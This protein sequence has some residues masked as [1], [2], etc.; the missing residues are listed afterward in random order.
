MSA[1]APKLFIS[2]RREETAGHAGRLYD[3]VAERFGPANVFM[4]VELAPGIDFVEQ[5]TTA[6][7]DCRALLVVIGPHWASVPVPGGGRSRLAEDGDYVRLEVETA[8]RRAD[9]RVIPVLVAGAR[10]PQPEQ[11]PESLRALAR[12]N[13]IELSDGRWRFDVGRLVDALDTTIAPEPQ[14]PEAE[15]AVRSA[16][17][18]VRPPAAAPARRPAAPQ[19]V[20]EGLAIAVVVG[21][22][23]YRA[24]FD[25]DSSHD[26]AG[27]KLPLFDHTTAAGIVRAWMTW[28]P[29]ALALAA[30]LCL[31]RREPR[32]LPGALL[33]ALLAGLLG[34]GAAGY[35]LGQM[36]HGPITDV[37]AIALV[38][39][40]VGGLLGGLWRPQ[41][42]LPA[43]AAG[44][45]AGAL[46]QALVNL[47][48]GYDL[49]AIVDKERHDFTVMLET[50][51][52]TVAALAL[53]L[54]L[55]ARD[56]DV[57]QG[58]PRGT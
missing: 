26:F 56:A 42:F 18:V 48:A 25:F 4:D 23:A 57:S 54:W 37:G 45:V 28:V 46:A 8:L 41:R 40:S 21:L 6:V 39:A 49:C 16:P 3:A 50:G 24:A 9:V 44:A 30:W 53:L 17:D 52:M 55:D 32:R 31:R 13:A 47:V 38:G 11:L 7:G 15:P 27:S 10:M 19:L 14:E 12:R 51:A 35:V 5:I 2:Y 29:V 34:A 43:A 1:V 20:A 22:L 33:A 36:W 58:P